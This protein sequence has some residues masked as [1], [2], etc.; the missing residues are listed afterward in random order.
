MKRGFT[1]IELLVVV[2]IIGILSAVALPQYQKAVKRAK[3]TELMIML[4]NM[5]QKQNLS[6]L[7]NG[8]VESDMVYER[9]NYPEL[10]YFDIGSWG[11]SGLSDSFGVIGNEEIA[12]ITHFVEG[13][14]N[15][16]CVGKC[17][18]YFTSPNCEN[19]TREPDTK[20]NAYPLIQAATCKL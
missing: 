13:K 2:L 14:S 10:K 15:R 18:D 1:L 7:E 11:G 17:K 3:T 4:A 5:E 8:A 6:Y 20:L 12:V 19:S 9:D 16:Y